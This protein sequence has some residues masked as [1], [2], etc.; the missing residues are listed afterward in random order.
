[1]SHFLRKTVTI[2]GRD[3]EPRELRYTLSD[4]RFGDLQPRAGGSFADPQVTIRFASGAA[5]HLTLTLEPTT[6]PGRIA[7]AGVPAARSAAMRRALPTFRLRYC[8]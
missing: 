6:V 5:T 4:G 2:T 7:H 1:M 3:G 8:F